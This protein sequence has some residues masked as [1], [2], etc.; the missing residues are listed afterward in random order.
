MGGAGGGGAPSGTGGGGAGGASTAML[1]AGYVLCVGCHGTNGE[2]APATA[3]MGGPEIKHPVADFATWVI[4]NGRAHPDF[5]EPMPK[6]PTDMLSDA[7]LQGILSYLSA[8]PKPTTGPALYLDYCANCHGANGAGGVTMRS[9]LNVTMMSA[10]TTS[11]RNGHHAGEF[12]NRRDFMP[13]WTA[14]QLSDAELQLIF[15]HI[16]SL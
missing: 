1:P 5:M 7:N 16:Q 9:L 6:F 10:L 3:T 15:Q 8:Q 13:K 2:G 14:A 4:R 11:V 12:S